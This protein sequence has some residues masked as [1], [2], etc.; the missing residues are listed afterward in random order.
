MT[1]GH[2]SPAREDPPGAFEKLDRPGEEYQAVLPEYHTSWQTN[3][4]FR[5]VIVALGDDADH[6][7]L[8][9]LYDPF[10]AR[11]IEVVGKHD[12]VSN[13][14]EMAYEKMSALVETATD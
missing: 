11:T 7:W 5:V 12:A 4:L 14:R 10:V 3:N 1:S 13:A 2:V 6:S 9:T 8:V